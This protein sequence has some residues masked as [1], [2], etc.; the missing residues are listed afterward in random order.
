MNRQESPGIHTKQTSKYTELAIANTRS[1]HMDSDFC[2]FFVKSRRTN[3]HINSGRTLTIK[4]RHGLI[5]MLPLIDPHIKQLLNNLGY[6]LLVTHNITINVGTR[7]SNNSRLPHI[8]QMVLLELLNSL[9]DIIGPLLELPLRVRDILVP[10]DYLA[11]VGRDMG[12]DGALFRNDIDGNT[13]CEAVCHHALRDVV[14]FLHMALVALFLGVALVSLVFTV[15][16]I[17]PGCV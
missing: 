13:T 9:F 6:S 3:S 4:M 1:W 15:V 5:Q 2:V 14:A 11:H 17:H 10:V 12:H 7:D 16:G 8:L